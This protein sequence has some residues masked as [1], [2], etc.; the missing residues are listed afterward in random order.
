MKEVTLI[1]I[2]KLILLISKSY[3]KGLERNIRHVGVKKGK[4]FDFSIGFWHSK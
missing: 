4:L 1:R 2:M 3:S